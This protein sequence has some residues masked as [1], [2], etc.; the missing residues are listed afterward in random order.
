MWVPA[1]SGEAGFELSKTI[2]KRRRL[3]AVS[4]TSQEV[5]PSITPT[6]P[7]ENWAGGSG[8]LLAPC[9]STG[10]QSPECPQQDFL[11]LWLDC[12]RAGEAGEGRGPAGLR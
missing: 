3:R 5:W 4:G 2:R 6:L 10:G 12:P 8:G 1:V 11:L 9:L 7:A